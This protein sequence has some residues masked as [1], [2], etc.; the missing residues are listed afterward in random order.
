MVNT[1]LYRCSRCSKEFGFAQ[2]K[3]SS[4]KQI[5]CTSCYAQ[6]IQEGKEKPRLYSGSARPV[7]K[8]QDATKY[9]CVNCRYQFNVKKSSGMSARCPYC[10]KDN[11]MEYEGTV[12]KILDEV[13]Q[14]PGE[15]FF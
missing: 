14:I 2:I 1:T 10:G 13:S 5:F 9:I 11:M 4:E 3:Y 8:A 12:S 7:A 6:A 15:R